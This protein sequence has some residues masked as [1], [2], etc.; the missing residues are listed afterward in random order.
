VCAHLYYGQG[1]YPFA[2]RMYCTGSLCVCVHEWLVCAQW[3]SVSVVLLVPTV[4]LFLHMY[5][6]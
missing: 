1:V 3:C 5:N 2:S 6:V 4:E